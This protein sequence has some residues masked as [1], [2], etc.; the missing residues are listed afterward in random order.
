[1]LKKNKNF[2]KI[3]RNTF[4]KERRY[5]FFIYLIIS[6]LLISSAF[7]SK[8][9]N[10]KLLAVSEESE[11]GSIANVY[12][13]IKE[14][15]GR[16]FIDSFPLSKIDTQISTRFAKEVA[17]NFLEIDCSNYDFFYTIKA[18]SAI[19]GGPSAGAAIAVLTVAVLADLDID[20]KATMTGTINTGNIIGPVGG[21]LPKISAASDVG[22]KKVLIPKY[23]GLNESNISEIE[24]KYNIKVVEV[25]FLEEALEELTGKKFEKDVSINISDSYKEIMLKVAEELCNRAEKLY[26]ETNKELKINE[27]E[28][29]EVLNFSYNYLQKGKNSTLNNEFYSSASYCFGSAL[30]SQYIKLKDDF[31]EYNTLNYEKLNKK[32]NETKKRIE[33]YKNFI[34]NKDLNTLSDLEV[35]MIVNDRL[36]EAEDRLNKAILIN[37]SNINNSINNSSQIINYNQSIYNLAYSIERLNSAISWANFFNMK[38]KKFSINKETM[39]DSCLKKVS[40]VEER[41]QY[42][43]FYIP[44]S[45]E[46]V[47]NSIKDSYNEY[48]NKNPELCIYK[49]SIAK[50][51][52]NLIL[53][54]MSVEID[55]IKDL[56]DDR[57]FSVKKVISKQNKRDIFPILAYSYYEY[58]NS[59]KNSDEY[60]SLLYL[61]YALEF[62]NL[63]IYFEKNK[64]KIP[65]FDKRYA[66]FFIGG[67]IIGVILGIAIK[68]DIDKIKKIKER[69]E[70][71]IR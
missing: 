23:S 66:Y 69:K 43:K 29:S 13:E 31:L 18:N 28:R 59:L 16:V 45:F 67:L 14:G 58:G 65:N 56:I 7:G 12:L 30:N 44:T 33:E 41:L 47:E 35:Y 68:Y 25:S 51:K 4:L 52:L 63:D 60:S 22:I 38:G 36:N 17:C 34:K 19:V 37:N 10:I 15:N 55:K 32:I 46:D 64:I 26:N 54:T 9:G 3:I 11:K 53:N 62:G 6:L 40:E 20:Q 1:M 8:S 49:A 24:K 2:L 71:K 70:K 50:A 42:L 27:Q 61:E 39:D 5:I 48:N 21:V 57:S